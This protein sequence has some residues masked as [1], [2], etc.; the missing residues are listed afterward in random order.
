[1]RF[2]EILRIGVVASVVWCGAVV[3]Q[4][5]SDNGGIDLPSSLTTQ[6]EART[7]HQS[8]PAPRGQITD[9][10][11]LPL[12]QSKIGHYVAIQYPFLESPS[13][14]DVLAFAAKQTDKINRVLGKAWEI[15]EERILDHYKNRRW[16]PLQFSWLLTDDQVA[17]IE[18]LAGE[19]TGIA[20]QPAYS[21]VYPRGRFAPHI[22]GYL[23]AKLKEMPS[24]PI[25]QGDPLWMPTEGRSGLEL[26]FEEF[27]AGTPGILNHLLD[28]DGNRRNEF[29]VQPPRPGSNVVTTLD[30]ELQAFVESK[31][32]EYTRRGAMV[33]LEI[34]TGDILAMA[35][36]PMFD[37]NVMGPRITTEVYSALRDDPTNPLFGRAF[38]AAYPPASTYKVP[39]A[40]AALESGAVDQYSEFSGPP[41]LQIGD[42]SMRNWNTKHEGSLNVVGALRRSCN[43]WFYQVGRKTGAEPFLSVSRRMGLGEDTGIPLQGESGGLVPLDANY[44][45][46]TANLSIGQGDLLATPLQVARMMAAVGDGVN[47]P[48]PRLVL[49][50]QDLNNNIVRS[51][52]AEARN[53]LGLSKHTLDVVRKGRWE[54]VNAGGGTGKR[55]SIKYCEIAGKTGTGE[56]K[57]S[58]KQNVAWFAGF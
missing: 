24:G 20:L 2:K 22:L 36:W 1:M 41:S 46:T 34:K 32:R 57:K 8:I 35:S 47:V 14:A 23:G 58:P 28:G 53:T 25:G 38:Q 48:V 4:G 51:Y 27:L 10:N 6:T 3:G 45:V 21:R 26:K 56:W 31:L 54:V 42:R 37:P 29:I 55:A 39:V 12:A 49:Q 19:G 5:V 9:R 15:P 40:L 18:P 50:V 17:K 43:T 16:L 44:S 13:D 33:V 11:G 7:I 52:P 30:A